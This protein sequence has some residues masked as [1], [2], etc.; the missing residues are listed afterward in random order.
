MTLRQYLDIRGRQDKWITL[1]V[2]IPCSAVWLFG[3]SYRW[4]GP[5]L[6]LAFA[7][8]MQIRATSIPMP[9]M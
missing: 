4:F 2:F 1:A 6:F 9:K 3:S 5:L 7:V 8:I